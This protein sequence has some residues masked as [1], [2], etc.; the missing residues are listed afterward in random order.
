[1]M[2]AIEHFPYPITNTILLTVYGPLLVFFD[3]SLNDPLCYGIYC[4][5]FFLH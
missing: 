1:M 2:I 3:T 4:L 5:S